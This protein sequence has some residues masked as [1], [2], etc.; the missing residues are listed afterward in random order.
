M[1]TAFKDTLK[2]PDLKRK[3]LIVIALL[4][5]YR[6]GCYIPVPGINGK[7]LASFFERMPGTLFG[8]AD[9]FAGGALSNATIFALGIMP[10]IS[11][12]IILQL[13]ASIFPYFEQ[14]LRS[15]IEGR[16]KL[17][18]WTRY[19]T[20]ILCLF[21]GFAV[22]VWLENP[23]HFDG[24]VMVNNPGWLFKLTTVL[25][26]TTGTVFLMWLGEQITEKGI[27]NGISLIIT[28]SILSRMPV[29]V[30]Q[31]AQLTSV[32]ELNPGLIVLMLGL[33]FV[34]VGAAIMLNE[35]ERRIPVQYAKRVVGR[36][37]Y[38]GQSTYL[39]IKLNP[40]GVLPL[41]FAVS[42]LT[43]PS[44][45]LRFTNNPFLQKLSHVLNPASG[46]GMLLYAL[47][48]IGFSY[49]YAS[50]IF[51]PD[52]ISED[53]KKYGGFVAGI[54][55]GKATGEYLEKI[56][57][58]LT[59]PGSLMLTAIAIFPYIIMHIFRIPYLIAS[60]FGGIGLLIVVSVVLETLRQIEAHLI[61]RHY[62]GFLKK[63]RTRTR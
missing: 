22:S 2:V 63:V 23:A 4:T 58:R 53:L 46:P 37:V 54:R 50:V 19:G 60:M 9:L 40:G 59:L 17:T 13:L 32:G 51:N 34:V 5:V 39:P 41:I 42:F 24:V 26:L 57:G 11:V 55:P 31:T 21:Q 6:F 30:H 15:G 35:G 20:V 56:L 7:A 16:R 29:A 25:T 62:E 3:I 52:H 44:T 47:L 48:I 14:M 18:L 27:G 28:A 36:K 10:Y 33:V 45:I 1:I 49:F 12:S 8:I 61:M 38:G 43:F